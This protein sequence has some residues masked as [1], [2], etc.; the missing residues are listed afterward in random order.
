MPGFFVDTD[1]Q[2]HWK[3]MEWNYMSALC[4]AHEGIKRMKEEGKKGKV[5]FTGSVLSLM[6]FAGFSTYSPSKYAIRGE[7]F[8]SL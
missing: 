5:V 4:T 2:Q 7:L 3:C 8:P 1:V 6:G